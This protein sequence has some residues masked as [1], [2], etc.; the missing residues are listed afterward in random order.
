MICILIWYNSGINTL[1]K[2][3]NVKLLLSG[4]KKMKWPL[5]ALSILVFILQC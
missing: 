4:W 3:V 1:N 5:V 2:L